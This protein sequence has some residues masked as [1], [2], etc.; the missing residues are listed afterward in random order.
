MVTINLPNRPWSYF[1]M[2]ALT[3]GFCG[4]FVSGSHSARAAAQAD[5][6]TFNK[7]AI[8]AK[9]WVYSSY[10][11]D[12]QMH[13]VTYDFRLPS[14]LVYTGDFKSDVPMHEGAQIPILYAKS[15]PMISHPTAKPTVLDSSAPPE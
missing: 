1:F 7:S 6:D 10:P 13:H 5:I 14:G 3:V 2:G 9:A 12:N 4:F 11:T 8:T 15:D